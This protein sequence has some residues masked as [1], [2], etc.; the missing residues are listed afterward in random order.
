MDHI[1]SGVYETIRM[2]PEMLS[3]G[4]AKCLGFVAKETHI[5]EGGVWLAFLIFTG[6][7]MNIPANFKKVFTDAQS[8]HKSKVKVNNSILFCCK[9]LGIVH[10]VVCAHL[11]WCKWQSRTLIYLLQPCHLIL[12]AQTI[13]LFASNELCCTLMVFTIPPMVG[14]VLATIFPDTSGLVLFME[15]EAYFI[16]HI[17]ITVVTPLCLLLRQSDTI[18]NLVTAANIF[19]GVWMLI[20]Y[21][22]LLLESIDYITTVNVDF[23][24]CPSAAMS[25][26]F[27][28]LPEFL[29]WPSYRSLMTVA[30]AL[31]A[32][33]LSWLHRG[34]ASY[35]ARKTVKEI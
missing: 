12:F 32:W 17:C 16:Q 23:M 7:Y 22:W 26:V 28:M 27:A 8:L 14:A 24:L 6:F 33:P 35:S 2:H 4:G 18:R 21:H 30:V 20:L 3:W 10:C 25:A 13:A 9:I 19:T 5:F 11:I 15:T 31:L 29:Q 34:I 1:A